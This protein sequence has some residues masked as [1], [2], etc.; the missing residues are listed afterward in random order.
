MG[1]PFSRRGKESG[2]TPFG[3]RLKKERIRRGFKIWEFSSLVG[4]A[5]S[6]VTGAENRGVMPR[7][8]TVI[9]MAQVLECSI[10]YLCGLEN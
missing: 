3:D 4:C 7:L 2:A 8:D 5:E 9:A 1:K 6:Q 10:D